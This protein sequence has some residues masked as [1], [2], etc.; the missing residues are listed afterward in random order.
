MRGLVGNRLSHSHATPT[1]H[2]RVS[3]ENGMGPA[4]A[5]CNFNGSPPRPPRVSRRGQLTPYTKGV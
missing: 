1:V 3:G 4:V 2:P 5:L